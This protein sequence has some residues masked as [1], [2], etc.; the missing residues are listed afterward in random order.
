M[1][2]EEL[3]KAI[4]KLLGIKCEQKYMKWHEIYFCAKCVNESPD[5]VDQRLCSRVKDY[6]QDHTAVQEFLRAIKSEGDEYIFSE[7]TDFIQDILYADYEGE[8]LLDLFLFSPRQ[9]AE[10]GAK[11]VGIWE[12]K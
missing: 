8:A 2:D 9:L 12:G 7:F 11:A 6:C 10:A 1:N 5:P 3:N 4:H